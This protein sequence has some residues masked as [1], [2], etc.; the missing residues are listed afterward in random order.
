M[1]GE[2]PAIAQKESIVDFYPTFLPKR[3]L[4]IGAEK[5]KEKSASNRNSTRA[6]SNDLEGLAP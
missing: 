5:G 6:C 2:A 3:K 1:R 4:Q